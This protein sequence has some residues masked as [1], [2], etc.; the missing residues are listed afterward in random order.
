M[1]LKS[2]LI[3]DNHGLVPIYHI[4]DDDKYKNR[5]DYLLRKKEN[6]EIKN[7]IKY[8]TNRHILRLFT[9]NKNI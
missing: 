3:L 6:V 1:L 7:Q 4:L 5:V 9:D 8:I 2:F